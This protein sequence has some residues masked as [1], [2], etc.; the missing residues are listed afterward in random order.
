MVQAQLKAFA[1]DD[2][3]KAF[4]FASPKLRQMLGTPD[5]FMSMVR[6]RYE[7]V[8]RPS[9]T[10][11]FKPSGSGNEA[12]LKLQLTDADSTIWIAT[13]SLQRLKNRAWVITGCQLDQAVGTMV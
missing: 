10:T 5:N 8:Y 13:Y 6:S 3:K 11:F 9:S 2:A 7:V 12:F 1:A 4:S